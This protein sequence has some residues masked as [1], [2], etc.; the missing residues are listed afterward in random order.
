MSKKVV[1]VGGVAG[2]ASTAARLRRLD[3][4]AEIIIM[5][6]GPFISFANC[7]L[8]YHIGG[9][10][11]NR[12]ELILQMPEDM[13]TR[14][15]VDV[16]INNEVTGINRDKKTVSVYNNKTGGKYE[17]SYD[18]LVLSPGS[19]PFVPP[20]P[21]IK[22]DNHFVLWT[23]PDMDKIISY[24]KKHAP[25]TAAVIGGGFIGLEMV[26]NLSELGIEVSLVEMMDQVMQPLDYD[27]AQFVHR[28]LS[29]HHVRLFLGDGV[30]EFKSTGVGTQVTLQSG[31]NIGVDLV[32]MAIGIR[33]NSKLALDAGLKT[34]KR[35]GIIVNKNLET[36]DPDIYAVGDAIEVEHLV[37]GEPTMIPLAGPANKQ[38][39]ICAD[40]IAGLDSTYEASQGTSVAK[41]FDLT[42]ATTGLNDK[43]LMEMGKIINKDYKATVVHPR[44][45][46]GY[47]PGAYPLT[48]K[49]LF[50]MN[51]KV[52]GAQSVG[53]SGVE[54]RIDVIAAAMRFGA[55]VYDLT[56][57]ELSYAPPYSSAKD[58]V[59]MAGFSAENI[60]T[61]ICDNIQCRELEN[62]DISDTIILDARTPGETKRGMVTGAINIP[63]DELRYRLDELDKDKQIIV[64]CAVGFRAYLA[65]RILLQNGF[66]RVRNLAGGYTTYGTYVRKYIDRKFV[67][68]PVRYEPCDEIPDDVPK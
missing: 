54:K 12:N 49:V 65:C 28:Q 22:A 5:E 39:R 35:G 11:S 21:G 18:K 24:I 33:P 38:G 37:T 29:K 34:N 42:V 47:Y 1:I 32:I 55:T 62:T 7:G 17:E 6:R 51:G 13:K 9:I 41:V 26:E 40:N 60:L 50:D 19:T 36:S 20:I 59:N 61:G 45:H 58:P 63:V 25:K 44:S 48:L 43:Q 67:E 27:M 53:H 64:Y 15:N 56:K 46:A 2:G 52:L 66:R 68:E 31:L 23:I 4:N 57:L 30:R 8:P 10:I 14:F 16:R 3:E